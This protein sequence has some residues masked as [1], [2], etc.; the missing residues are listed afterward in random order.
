MFFKLSVIVL[1]PL[2]GLPIL[3]IRKSPLGKT[4]LITRLKA[5]I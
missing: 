2:L 3:F 5:T 4:G 1:L